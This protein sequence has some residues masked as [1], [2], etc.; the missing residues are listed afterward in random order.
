[1]ST[2]LKKGGTLEL[3]ICR[4]FP[5]PRD[6]VFDAWTNKDHLSKWMGPTPEIT[7][8]LT[9][10]NARKGGS[11]RF[12]FGEKDCSDGI[13]YVH[14]EYLEISRP[15]KLVFTWICEPP[16]E[17]A[18]IETLVTVEFFE[19]ETGTEVVLKHQRFATE[20]ACEKHRF[21]WEGTFTKQLRYFEGKLG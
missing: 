10:V 15:D 18:G 21:G 16:L 4:E 14:G 6:M 1:M 13:S 12:G 17:E 8:A 2:E 7:L 11:Y 9:E 20:D 19:T 5:F 3:E